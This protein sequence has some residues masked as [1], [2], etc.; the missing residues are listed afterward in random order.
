M[1]FEE[2]STDEYM[3]VRKMSYREFQDYKRMLLRWLRS[4]I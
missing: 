4:A 3:Y 2:V 1:A